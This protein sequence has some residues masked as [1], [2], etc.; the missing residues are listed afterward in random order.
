M[1]LKVKGEVGEEVGLPTRVSWHPLPSSSVSVLDT[2]LEVGDLWRRVDCSH[3]R[4]S[5]EKPAPSRS[6]SICCA[7][8]TLRT[9]EESI[10]TAGAGLDSKEALHQTHG[11][12]HSACA[13]K[14]GSPPWMS[15]GASHT[16]K[17]IPIACV[18]QRAKCSAPF[19]PS[20]GSAIILG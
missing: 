12:L 6:W 17:V 10:R 4:F 16:R 15:G 7:S 9:A 2:Q 13:I 19:E 5:S 1:N 14:R 8:S 18:D 11:E 20:P 3:W